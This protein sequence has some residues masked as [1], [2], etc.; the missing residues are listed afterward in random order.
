MAKVK[1][2]FK[3]HTSISSHR[4]TAIIWANLEDRGMYVELG[5]LAIVKYA[6]KTGNEFWLS[7]AEMMGVTCCKSPS[8]SASRVQSFMRRCRDGA[9]Q[10]GGSSPFTAEMVGSGWRVTFRNL[11][12]KQGFGSGSG[13]VTEPPDTEAEAEAEPKAKEHRAPPLPPTGESVEGPPKQED[14]ELKPEQPTPETKPKPKRDLEPAW[15]DAK[16]AFAEYG[17]T[18]KGP[19]GTRAKR[20]GALIDGYPKRVN[21]HVQ[22]VHG[23]VYSNR[24]RSQQFLETY[25]RPDTVWKVSGVQQNL[26]AFDEAAS[27]GVFPP[28]RREAEQGTPKRDA[29]AAELVRQKEKNAK[30]SL[31]RREGHEQ[32][33]REGSEARSTHDV[34][35]SL[36]RGSGVIGEF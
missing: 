27:K 35:S 4:N 21:P 19:V 16:A 36:R 12:K 23:W 3:T 34:I 14:L 13:K 5:R 26:D 28:F 29:L 15:E 1:A 33:V 9:E 31:D 6:A 22:A 10:L 24:L 17:K 18:F 30:R 8:A 25:C 7:A 32:R 2:H 20:L 11:S